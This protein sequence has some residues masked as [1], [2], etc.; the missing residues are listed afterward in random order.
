MKHYLTTYSGSSVEI[1]PRAPFITPN[2][3]NN[4]RYVKT[5]YCLAR[6]NTEFNKIDIGTTTHA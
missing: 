4:R 2:I 6:L 1:D 5:F 3:T